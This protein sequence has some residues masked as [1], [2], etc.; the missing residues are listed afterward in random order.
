MNHCSDGKKK[1]RDVWQQY[2]IAYVNCDGADKA[3]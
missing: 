1:R 3:A 2:V